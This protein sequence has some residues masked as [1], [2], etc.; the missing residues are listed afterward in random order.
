MTSVKAALQCIGVNT[1]GTVSI[2]RQLFG[3]ARGRVPGDPE[4]A[5]VSQVSIREQLRALDG[6]HFHLNVIRVGADLFTNPDDFDKIDYAIYRTRIIYR[7]AD[8]GLGRVLH[9]NINEADAD[10]YEDI[11]SAAEADEMIHHWSVDNNGL[12][13]FIVDNIS[14]G[15]IGKAGCIDGPCDKDD[16]DPPGILGGAADASWEKLARTF[17]H[18]IGHYL[19][20]KHNHGGDTCPTSDSG[21][22][23]LMAQTKCPQDAGIPLRE[24]VT[25]TS[26]ERS[27]IRSH[28]LVQDGC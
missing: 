12:D 9:Y 3:F 22:R 14:A 5:V 15:F 27:T 2:L 18:E 20:L 23:R 1:S 25:L 11:G 19:G 26:G 28:C 6:D 7:A 13:A 8:L 17:P 24:A 16:K 4:P 10:G 21:N